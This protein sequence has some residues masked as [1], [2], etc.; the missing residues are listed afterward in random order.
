LIAFLG[1]VIGIRLLQVLNVNAML[2]T[3]PLG[4]WQILALIGLVFLATAVHEFGHALVCTLYGAP[5]RSMGIMLYY[6]QPA[7]Y[8]DVTDSWRL[9]NKWHRA[10][11]SA[12]GVYVQALVVAVTAAILLVL[13]IHGKRSDLLLLYCGINLATMIFNLLPFVKLDGY[14][15][16]SSILGIPNLRDRAMEWLQVSIMRVLL[17]RPVDPKALRYN[18][19]LLMNP[20]SRTLLA[21]F[22]AS[23]RVFGV[24]MWLAGAGFLF[25]VAGWLHVSGT[26]RF[27]VVG[28]AIFLALVVFVL[29]VS[30]D[31]SRA[32][33]PAKPA[34]VQQVTINYD[35]D[36]SR[37]IRLNP[38]T[39][40]LDDNKGNTLFAWAA[41]DQFSVPG[42]TRVF[43]AVPSLRRGTTLRDLQEM[44]GWNAE[45]ESVIQRL[46]HLKHLRYSAEWE[47]SAEDQRYSRQLGWFSLSSVVRGAEDAALSR[48]KS[49]SVTVLGVGGV[50]SNVALNLAACG[51]GELHLVDG[52]R[53]ELSNLNRQLLYTPADVGKPK[54]EVAAER[55]AQFDPS[56]R[57]RTTNLYLNSADDVSRVIAGSDY[58]IRSLDSPEDAQ[59]WVNQACMQHGIPSTGAGFMAQNA[60]VGPTVIPG[61]TA[62]LECHQQPLPRISRGAGATF[63]P[64]VTV[65]AGIL[66]NEVVTYLGKLGELR[67]STGMLLIEAP[68]F[69][70]RLLNIPR[71]ENCPVCGTRKNVAATFK[72]PVREVA[73]GKEVT[74]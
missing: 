7:A 48:L 37:P 52:D 23:S 45:A 53:V 50:G 72:V 67:T 74:V 34:P 5:V 55:L 11:I 9:K 30:R 32:A 69:A 71:S 35:I 65:T 66:A 33:A 57:I 8:A 15:I 63:G 26:G 40:V 28:G 41:T 20:I 51:I 29:R 19:V 38:F 16:L 25:R 39:T 14:W 10:A 62:C 42:S 61:I 21:C 68:T 2:Q 64:I 13:R 4:P 46:W 31:R 43:D 3:F 56:L 59:I 73:T 18:A 44:S 49:K 27:F 17:R 24:G 54:V 6:F 22:G 60:F 12:A 1:V 47:I 36:R 58:V 70:T